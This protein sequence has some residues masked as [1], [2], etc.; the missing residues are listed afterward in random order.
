[1]EITLFVDEMNSFAD[2]NLLSV[3]Q[4]LTAKKSKADMEL[5]IVL[6]WAN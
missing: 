4:I 1:M 2:Q 5:I 3:V 6:C